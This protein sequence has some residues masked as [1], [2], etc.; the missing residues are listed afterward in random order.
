MQK[1]AQP[2]V[3]MHRS[4]YRG[5]LF[6]SILLLNAC[7]SAPI[8]PNRTPSSLDPHGPGAAK[9]AELWWVMYAFGLFVFVL[10]VAILIAALLRKR[11]ATSDTP[12]EGNSDNGRNWVILGG[13]ALPVV[14]IAI[15]FG[16]SIHTLAAVANT[17]DPALKVEVV[18]RRW[19][20][21]IN[22]PEQGITTA[23]ELH[24]PVDVDV[25]IQL[26]SGDVIHSFWV[27]QLHGKMDVIPNRVNTITIRADEA[28]VYRGECAEYCGLQHAHMGFMVV[29]EASDDFNT[30]ASAQQQPAAPPE[31]DAAIRGQQVFL[32]AGCVFCHTV[33]GLGDREVDVT[34]VDLGP[35]LTHLYSRLTIAGASLT[36]NRGNLAGWVVDAQH[37]KPGSLM[38]PMYLSSDDLQAL[39]AYLE[40]LD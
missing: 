35:D 9:L 10:V 28:G 7:A 33:R 25:Q 8:S 20:W 30:W 38:P 6:L 14:I 24:I 11:R 13:I 34:A 5:G 12:P 4:L 22:Y 36:T 32:E 21:E 17:E 2:S 3:N 1:P 19:W 26:Q 29:A 37:V 40:S 18:G 23:N 16:Y 27:P 31:D 39:L 15:V